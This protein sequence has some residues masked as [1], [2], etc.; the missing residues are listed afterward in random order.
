M[1]LDT[2]DTGLEGHPQAD[3]VGAWCGQSLWPGIAEAYASQLQSHC[4]AQPQAL[5]NPGQSRQMQNLGPGEK[6]FV[7]LLAPQVTRSVTHCLHPRA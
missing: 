5:P 6:T 1:E 3:N 2:G 4:L 7:S